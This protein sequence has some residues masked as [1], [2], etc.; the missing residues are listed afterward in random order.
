MQLLEDADTGLD[1]AQL[2]ADLAEAGRVK[3]YARL[4]E[5]SGVG[6]P[7]SEVRDG[8]IDRAVW[9]RIVAEDKVASIYSTGSVRL[10]G[11]TDPSGA[12]SVLGIR[13]DE[14]SVKAAAVEHG[15]SKP[16]SL[17][18]ERTAKPVV[19]VHP[20][21]PVAEVVQAVAVE[22]RP[23]RILPDDAV[24]MSV[25][26]ASAALGISRG[27]VYKLMDTGTLESKKVGGRRLVSAA[28]VRALLTQS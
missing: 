12:I 19:Q 25:D 18:A 6:R 9:K 15:R 8:R 20:A 26:E 22:E 21:E 17:P 23:R 5:V 2:L 10:G 14:K 16:A 28:S 3:G 4:V 11:D 1:C 13:F 7:T 24:A 27:T